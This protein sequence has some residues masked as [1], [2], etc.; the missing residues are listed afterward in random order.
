MYTK[1]IKK[2][3]LILSGK[4]ILK[5]AWSQIMNDHLINVDIWWNQYTALWA[6]ICQTSKIIKYVWTFQKTKCTSTAFWSQRSEVYKPD[7]LKCKDIWPYKLSIATI[8]TIISLK[9]LSLWCTRKLTTIPT[10][11]HSLNTYK[12]YNYHLIRSNMLKLLRI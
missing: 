12:A 5:V 2:N 7:C 3:Y 4:M 1:S 9:Y 11:H 10:I 6:C 8:N